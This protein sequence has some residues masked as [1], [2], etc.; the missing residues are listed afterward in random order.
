MTELV[1]TDVTDETATI[2]LDN[3]DARNA[4]SVELATQLIDA[5][6]E[7]ENTDAR[8]LVVEGAGGYFC[9]GG[10]IKAM[11]EGVS[12]DVDIDERVDRFGLPINHAVQAVYECPLPTIA[13]VDGPAF[14]AGGALAIACDVVLASER[15][16]ISFGFRQV[17]LSVDSGTSYLLPRQVGENVAKE[18]VYTGE[19]VDSDRANRLGLFNHVYPDDEFQERAQELVDTVAT[20]PTVALEESKRLIEAGPSRTFAEA[21]D[22]EAD[23]LRTTLATADHAEG[24]QSFVEQRDPEFEGQ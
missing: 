7:V 9:A 21:V 16:R 5:V 8:C 4:L 14:G 22:A 1:R 13:K 17:G 3:P 6:A 18:L 20:G 23:A 19:L 15:A 10:D 11:V 2:T 12:A 24:A